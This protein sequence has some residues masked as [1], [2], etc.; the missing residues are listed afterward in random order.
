[1]T[2]GERTIAGALIASLV[3]LLSVLIW[4]SMA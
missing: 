3:F 4:L 1:M 2:I